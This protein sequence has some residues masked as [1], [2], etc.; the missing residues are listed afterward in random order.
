MFL[1][2]SGNPVAIKPV[3]IQIDLPSEAVG[4]PDATAKAVNL[5]AVIMAVIALFAALKSGDPIAIANA[6]QALIN[7]FMG[8]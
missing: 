5:I 7:A 4:D 3:T 8:A 2:A 1:N 6:L